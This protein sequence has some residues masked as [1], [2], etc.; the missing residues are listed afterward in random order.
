[1]LNFNRIPAGT[2][3]HGFTLLEVMVAISIIAIVLVAVYK[4]HL[5]TISMSSAARFYATAP[6]LAQGRLSALEADALSDS[7]DFGEHFPG[8]TWELAIEDIESE[9]LGEAAEDLKRIEVTVSLNNDYVYKV[10]TYRLILEK[11]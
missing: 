4:L 8:Y 10:K 7:G 9:V 11:G 1:M 2:S 3:D 5:Q 6:L